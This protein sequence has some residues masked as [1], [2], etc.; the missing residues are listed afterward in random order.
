MG[1]KNDTDFWKHYNENVPNS[2][3]EIF[4]RWES[5][6]PT[7]NEFGSITNDRGFSLQNWFDVCYGLNLL[8]LDKINDAFRQNEWFKHNDWFN[9]IKNNQKILSEMSINHEEM[10]KVLGGYRKPSVQ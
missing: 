1:K 7:F 5:A 8:N 4:S 3:K 10:I 6:V 9:N 2:I